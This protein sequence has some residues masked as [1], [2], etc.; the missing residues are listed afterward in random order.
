MKP[1][2]VLMVM[3]ISVLFN[4]SVEAQGFWK[5]LGQAIGAVAEAAGGSILQEAAVSSGYSRE[6][7]AKFTT[8]VYSALELNT[9]NAQLGMD[10][11]NA[12]NK[13]EKQNVAKE[14]VFDAAGNISDNQIFIDKFRI[15]TDTQLSYL[16]ENKK[17]TTQEEKQAAFDKRTKAYADLFYDT[18]QE[19]KERK[20]A[21]L[22]E[23]MK[24]KE[25]LTKSGH[26]SDA[27]TAEE[28]AGSIIA[29]QKSKDFSDNEKE[30]MLRSYGFYESPQQIQQF[31]NEVLADNSNNTE[32][33]EKEAKLQAEIKKQE[34]EARRI[35]EEKAVEE[36]RNALEKVATAKING[37]TFDKTALS[38]KQKSELDVV[39]GILNKYSDAKVLIVGHTCEIGYKNINLKKGLKRAEAGSEYLIERGISVERIS[40]ESKGEAEPLVQNLSEENRKQNRRIEFIVR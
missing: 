37:Y 31:V 8:D 15:M 17:A 20:A 13:Y 29:I 10:W 18:Y 35:A 40:V 25:Q 39:V 9:R 28:V 33:A 7:A 5:K 1:K 2:T 27:I 4:T 38:D 19:G 6:D 3:A 21:L 24:I 14:F 36:R 34:E 11:N 12:E 32:K 16:S 26:Y 23:K 22:V 30:E